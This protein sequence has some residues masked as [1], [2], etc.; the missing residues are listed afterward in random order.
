M[1][2]LKQAGLEWFHMLHS[3]IQSIGY[4]QSGHDLCLYV[5]DPETIMVIY[6]DNLLTFTPKLSIVRRKKE[7]SGRYKMC[8]LSKACWFLVMDIT[9]DHVAQMSSID[10]H[11]YIWK[12]IRHFELDN[13]QPVSTP[14]ATNLKLPKL[15]SLEIDQ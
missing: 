13:M 9:C 3:H 6:V 14:M 4:A 12:I 1:Y 2:G 8:D 7:L 5:L 15:E 11:Q 10:Q